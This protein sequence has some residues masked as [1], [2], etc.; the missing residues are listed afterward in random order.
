MPL[1]FMTAYYIKPLTHYMKARKMVNLINYFSLTLV[2][3]QN[4]YNVS[5]AR[6]LCQHLWL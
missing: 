6:S 4:V 1:K 5:L 2:L 3:L